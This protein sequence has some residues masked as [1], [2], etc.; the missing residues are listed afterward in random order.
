MLH[1]QA[2]M[3]KQHD[4]SA[5]QC[6]FRSCDCCST[7][8]KEMPLFKSRKHPLISSFCGI[9]CLTN[10]FTNSK[11]YQACFSIFNSL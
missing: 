11:G 7:Q 9:L 2:L 10:H 5:E 3:S 6:Q 4:K 1:L 8:E